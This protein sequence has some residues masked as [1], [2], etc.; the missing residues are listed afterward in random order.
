MPETYYT[1]LGV[2]RTA[3]AAEIKAA[4]RELIRQ[5]HPDVIPNAP[6]Y[7]KKQAEQ[8]SKE[9][10]EAYQVLS[11][12]WKRKEY[13]EQL[14]AYFRRRSQQAQ[15]AYGSGAQNQQ[16]TQASGPAYRG[17]QASANSASAPPYSTQPHAS[18]TAA[19]PRPNRPARAAWWTMWGVGCSVALY[20]ETSIA[21]AAL[22]FAGAL[23]FFACAAW[24]FGSDIRDFLSKRGVT[25]FSRQVCI[26]LGAISAVLFG[27]L[28][29]G[30]LNRTTPLSSPSPTE[31]S[32]PAQPPSPP[33]N[34]IHRPGAKAGLPEGTGGTGSDGKRY[35][36]KDG[37][38]VPQP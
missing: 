15:A 19:R 29:A 12:S 2:T 13:D 7:W 1:V 5:V 32:S 30:A 16:T 3:S 11:N 14:D 33:E 36:V 10:N 9:I 18:A 31:S 38:W 34:V 24:T 17:T 6:P 23:V 21:G 37:V 27:I 8:K 4:Y 25:R 20:S 35:V 28:A 26:T 22:A